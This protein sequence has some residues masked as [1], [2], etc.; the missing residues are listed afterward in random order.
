MMKPGKRRM[1]RFVLLLLVPVLLVLGAVYFYAMGG[2]TV[3]TEN[4]YVRANVVAISSEI[5]G[6]VIKVLVDDNQYVEREQLLFVIDPEPFKIELDASIAEM[7]MVEQEVHSLRAQYNENQVEISNAAERVRFLKNELNRQT[8]LA[9]TGLGSQVGLATAEHDLETAR[10]QRRLLQ[11]RKAKVIAELGGSLDLPIEKH[12][13][14]LRALSVRNRAALELNRTQVRASSAG[15]LGNV[16]LEVGEQVEA[17]ETVFPLVV[18]G[19]AWIEANLKEVHMAHVK[20]GQ[21]ARVK[22]DSY[23][24]QEFEATVESLSPATGAEFSLLPAQNA[25]GNWVKVVQRVPVKLRLKESSDIPV[26]RAGLTVSVEIETGYERPLGRRI[27]TM[28]AGL[29]FGHEH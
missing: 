4:A 17:G 15:Y 23:E 21:T 3:S 5:D 16:T 19:D 14:Y 11:Q 25:T 27:K 24:D 7:G 13:R 6:R 1:T 18:S 29:G 28:M 22:I 9:A 10:Q 26:L 2:S 12:P 8:R 20:V